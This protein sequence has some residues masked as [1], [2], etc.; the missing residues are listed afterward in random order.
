MNEY[1]KLMITS[2]DVFVVIKGINE[3][4]WAGIKESSINRIIYL[5]S[6]LYS[7]MFDAHENPFHN[8]YSFSITLSGPEDASIEQA[9]INLRSNDAIALTENGYVISNHAYISTFENYPSYDEKKAWLEDICYIISLYGE[10]KIYDFVFRD[11]QYQN[12][13]KTNSIDPLNISNDNVT[14]EFLNTFKREFEKNV[15]PEHKLSN[16]KYLKLYFEYVFGKI[17]RGDR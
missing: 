13:I 7:F 11:P 6:V 15:A 10:G 14:V 9:L 1:N 12:S 4:G 8:N 5:S 2:G 3:K 17:L 16:R